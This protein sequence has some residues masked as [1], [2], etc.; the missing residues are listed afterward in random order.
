MRM[1]HRSTL[2][3]LVPLAL[4]CGCEIVDLSMPGVPRGYRT[5]TGGSP[6]NRSDSTASATTTPAAPDTVVFACGVAFPEGYEWQRDTAMG[7]VPSRLVLYR[8]T[9]LVLSLPTGP[10]QHLNPF[11][12]SHHLAGGHVY[13]EYTAGGHSWISRDGEPLFDY[14]GSE[15][16][17]GLAVRDGSVFSLG[18]DPVSGDVT[19]RKDGQPLL[20]ISGGSVFGG[21]GEDVPALYE[22]S[23][24]VCF[25]YS[26]GGAVHLARDGVVSNAVL[27]AGTTA[28]EDY[29]LV[30]GEPCAVY[31]NGGY[32]CWSHSG[33]ESK[34][35][36]M[37]YSLRDFHTVEIGDGIAVTGRMKSRASSY[38]TC[39]RLDGPGVWSFPAGVIHIA[40]GPGG[41]PRG[42]VKRPFSVLEAVSGSS[43][44]GTVL[45]S[46]GDGF[47]ICGEAAANL[48]GHVYA[49]LS[50]AE[51]GRP[52]LVK[53][54]KKVRE[55]PFNG[56]ICGI[57]AELASSPDDSRPEA[58]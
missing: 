22:D 34:I 4:L 23:G 10:A 29:R 33:K 8:D 50:S 38:S 40:E 21:F 13:S 18:C 41:V 1:K 46:F 39:F 44:G 35:I 2:Y 54:G 32:V 53:D 47:L 25:A 31:E 11:P 49:G 28:V 3:L 43:E 48:V 26:E 56:F 27:P 6:G 24:Q 14:G 37:T 16:L 20:Q 55:Y 45:Y 17:K 19:L 5:T 57:E 7:A 42:I 36:R 51:G 52:Y 15:Y 30:G 12:D 58:L 9:A